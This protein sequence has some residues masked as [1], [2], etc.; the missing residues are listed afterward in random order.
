MDG[1]FR[2]FISFCLYILINRVSARV[3]AGMRR[4]RPFMFSSSFA[5]LAARTGANIQENE[6]SEAIACGAQ[7]QPWAFQA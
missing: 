2:Q 1:V 4:V 7:P 6:Y 5:N 3:Q